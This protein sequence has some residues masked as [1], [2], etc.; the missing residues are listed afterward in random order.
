RVDRGAAPHSAT[1]SPDGYSPSDL[2]SAYNL[3]TLAAKAGFGST[4][5]LIDAFDDPAAE[6]DLAVYRSNFGLPPC[7]TANGCFSK[8]DQS[9]GTHYPGPPPPGDNWVAEIG[10]D[11]DMVSAICPNCK[12]ILIEADSDQDNSL[13]FAEDEAVALGATEISNS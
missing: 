1:A 2:Q 10:L 6:S 9:G 3:S 13:F 5:A 11:L 4:V 12:I 8:V 7:T